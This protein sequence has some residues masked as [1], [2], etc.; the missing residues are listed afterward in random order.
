MDQGFG[1]EAD[2]A[3]PKGLRFREVETAEVFVNDGAAFDG[4]ANFI[5]LVPGGIG[6]AKCVSRLLDRPKLRCGQGADHPA[7]GGKFDKAV[8]LFLRVK[9]LFDQNVDVV[10]KQ[11]SFGDGIDSDG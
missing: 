7:G 6:T 9:K 8:E 5:G 10:V 3:G 1:I 2:P 11:V 4:A